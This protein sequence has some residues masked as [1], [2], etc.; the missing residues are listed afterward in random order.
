MKRK[1]KIIIV[2][3]LLLLAS[4]LYFFLNPEV[5]IL[6]DTGVFYN[7]Q[8]DLEEGTVNMDCVPNQQTAISIAQTI[9]DSHFT[10]AHYFRHEVTSV[11]YDEVDEVWV[12]NFGQPSIGSIYVFG[13]SVSIA[14]KKSNAQVLRVWIGI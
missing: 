14:I 11:F 7:N 13:D 9:F 2:I 12:V 1:K 8:W 4:I 6:Y 10:G 3:I 5:K